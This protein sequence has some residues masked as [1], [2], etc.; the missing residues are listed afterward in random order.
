M[1]TYEFLGIENSES[2]FAYYPEGNK[3]APGKIAVLQDGT[4]RIIEE[5]SEDFGKRYAY[6]AIN[7]ID[8]T[9]ISGTVAWY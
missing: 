9:R 1:L 6:H 2:L 4:G 7:G 3:N 5:S 8:T